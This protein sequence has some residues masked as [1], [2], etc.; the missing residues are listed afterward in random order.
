VSAEGLKVFAVID[1]SAEASQVG[2]QLRETTLVAFGDPPAGTPVMVAAPLA[3]LDLPLK[4]PDL[5]RRGQVKVSYYGP[6]ARRAFRPGRHRSGHRRAD[7]SV[8]PLSGAFGAW[9]FCGVRLRLYL[10]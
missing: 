9:F 1:P 4:V 7:R 10:G 6:S 3:A 5:G 2:V 8:A